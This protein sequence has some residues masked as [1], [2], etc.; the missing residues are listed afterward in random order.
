MMVDMDPSPMEQLRLRESERR[1]IIED[2]LAWQQGMCGACL[3][4]FTPSRRP[5]VDHNHRTGKIRGALCTR[6]NLLLGQVNEDLDLLKGL[7]EYLENNPADDC[8]TEPEWWP[9]SPGA[10]GLE[11]H[12]TLDKE[13]LH[14]GSEG[15]ITTWTGK[16]VNP[17]ALDPDLV[18]IFDIARALS[19][20][21]R[22]NG[23]VGGFLSVA[24]HS[25]W[26]AD[27]LG[28]NGIG[29]PD[30]MLTGLLHDAAET[31]L[32]DL[33]RPLK[34]SEFGKAYLVAEEQ[35][36]AAIAKRFGTPFPM[37]PEVKEADSWVLTHLELAGAVGDDGR[38]S[39]DGARMGWD[40]TPDEDEDEFLML[41]G[42]LT[43]GGL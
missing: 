22:Y 17:L 10:A 4:P 42:V 21:C 7:V 29:R 5:A 27:R 34:H 18:D 6:C 15:S 12:V 26:V 41:Y 39:A 16:R 28:M 19:R 33:V 23:H 14:I 2:L 25:I 8:W 43:G 36:E 38:G 35:A 3:R 30:L 32:G 20:Q 31:Y 24:R 9:G 40:S 11:H 13:G 1:R 37:P